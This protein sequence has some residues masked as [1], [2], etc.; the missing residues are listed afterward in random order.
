MTMKMNDVM[1]DIETLGKKR[2]C[3]VLSIA[4]V[5][6]NP[7]TGDIGNVF[8]ERMSYAAAISYGT[9]EISTIAWWDRQ[10]VE[11][12]DAAFNGK[13][14][15]VLVASEFRAFIDSVGGG[16]CILWGN[17]SVF[18]I[19]ILEGWLDRV[20]PLTDASG[21]DIYP[22]KYW[23][24]ADL[25][26]LVRL[27]G[28]NIKDIPFTGD[29]HN[30]LADALNQVKIAHIA[31]RKLMSCGDYGGYQTEEIKSGAADG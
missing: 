5:Q 27:A 19:T 23:N 6:F 30:A 17:G 29:K 9:P 26:T 7:H 13:R 24:I 1:I 25:R 12:R 22:W 15:P 20:D 18:D 3:P 14:L 31:S 10:S 4:A 16:H 28:I 21:E 8:Y 2:G 11:A